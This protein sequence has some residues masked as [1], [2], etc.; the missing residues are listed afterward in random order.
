M[1]ALCKVPDDSIGAKLMI[2]EWISDFVFLRDT[3]EIKFVEDTI[4]IIEEQ[5]NY[6]EK[7]IALCADYISIS[8]LENEESAIL[9]KI[10]LSM[11][12]YLVEL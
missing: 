6:V 2:D 4:K 7:F 12:G 8:P 9:L 3:R 11:Q 10:K 5:D 1:A